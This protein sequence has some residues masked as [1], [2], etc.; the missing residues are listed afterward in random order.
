MNVSQTIK[1]RVPLRTACDLYGIKINIGGFANCIVHHEKTPSMKLYDDKW[2]CFGCGASGDVIDLV[3]EMFSLDYMGA[4][5]R[6]N[7]DFSLS[8]PLD[9]KTTQKERE[10]SAKE[11]WK[12]NKQRQALEN[13]QK[14]LEDAY[15]NAMD[16]VILYE[17]YLRQYKPTN[18]AAEIHPLFVEALQNIEFSKYNLEEAEIKLNEFT[19]N[20]KL[21]GE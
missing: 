13:E 4:V 7:D 8:L 14:A 20:R 18:E 10:T 19:K 5:R 3:K 1:S 9:R 16:E 12:L 2:H 21:H 15:F 11:A 6:L 17:R